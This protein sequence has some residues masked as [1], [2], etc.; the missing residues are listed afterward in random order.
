MKRSIKLQTLIYN[1]K[2]EGD[3]I[4]KM[5][6]ERG[7]IT[8]DDISKKYQKWL[9]LTTVHQQTGKPRI[10]FIFWNIKFIKNVS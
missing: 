5:R 10:S 9:L 4:T 1:E 2:K 3:Q 8:A 6:N 7:D